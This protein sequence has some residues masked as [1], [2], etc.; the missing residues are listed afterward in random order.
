M[1]LSLFSD[2]SLRVLI[3]A[4]SK[5]DHFSI[6]EVAEAYRISRHHLVK[7]INQLAHLGYLETRR[8]RG[9]GICLGQPAADIRI[10]DVVRQ[11]DAPTPLVECFDH[12]TNTCAIHHHCLLKHSLAQAQTAFFKELNLYSL[13]DL[14]TGARGRAIMTTLQSS[15]TA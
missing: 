13:A 6:S 12:T 5:G 7:I 4:A 11:T 2:Y 14:T 15:S 9:G 8:G 10:G 1:R 3:Y